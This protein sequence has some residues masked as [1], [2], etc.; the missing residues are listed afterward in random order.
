MKFNYQARTKE[1]EIRIGQLNVPSEEAAINFLQKRELYI[2]SLELEKKAEKKSFLGDMK[3]FK[4]VS[5]KDVVLFSR[6]LSIMFHSK[7]PL[8][9]ALRVFSGQTENKFFKEKIL[10]ISQEVEGGIT[11][12]R[13]L[14]LHPKVFSPFYVAMVK[15]GEVSGKLAEA[16]DYLAKHTEREY[17][18]MSKAKGALIYP[19]LIILVIIV[20]LTILVLFVIPQLFGILKEFNVPLPF[21]TRLIF[22]I[23]ENIRAWGF[24][25]III[26]ALIM[27]FSI[28]FNKTKK[29]KS[30]FDHLWLKI[31]VVGGVLKMI[32]ITRF[33]ENL[34]TLIAGGLPIFR[35]LAVTRDILGNTAYKDAVLKTQDAVKK[36]ETMSS[37]LFNYYNLFPP[38]FVQ[39]VL[40]GEK[41]GTLGT[42]LM[43]IVSFYQKE[44]DRTIDSALALLEPLLMIFLG[45]VVG[46][47]VVA[48]LLPLYQ[49][50]LA[51]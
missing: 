20:V 17:H 28:H 34:S 24:L 9:E 5:T 51:M 47:I 32:Y 29:G 23:T 42:T 40:V 33:A 49:G 19:A 3:F 39:M 10:K 50:M 4:K 2:T 16:L 11:F 48:I 13:A 15:S 27:L 36:G 44:V 41:T 1:G 6:Q 35:A 22:G 30:F 38:V 21:I 45:V 31:P 25:G 37:V 43:D 46:A 26:I 12:S 18:L 14:A 8:V 7:V